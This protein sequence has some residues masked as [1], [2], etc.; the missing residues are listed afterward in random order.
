MEPRKIALL[1]AAIVVALVTALGARSLIKNSSAPVASAMPMPVQQT[2]PK[3]LVATR[4]LPVGTILDDASF[5]YQPWPKG[6]IEG[7]YYVEGDTAHSPN[8]LRGGVVRT[9]ISAG[10]PMTVGSVVQPGDRGFLAAALAPGMRAVTVP[11]SVA[12][13]VAGFV[14]P[15]DRIDIVLT[16]TVG[17]DGQGGSALRTSETIVRNLRVLATDQR[18]VSDDEKGNKEVKQFQT[19]T[20]EVTPRI[21]EKI[22][23]AQKIGDLS[24]SLRPI[25]DNASELERAIASGSVNMP[26]GTDPKMEKQMLVRIASQPSDSDTTYV[27]GADVSRFQRRSIPKA[28]A[29]AGASTLGGPSPSSSSPGNAPGSLLAPVVPRGPI[30]VIARGNATTQ[31]ETGGK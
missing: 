18:T 28:A 17:A 7:A 10:Q 24:L 26:A 3:V 13:G 9:A 29:P 20:L 6:L 22:A 30:V 4:A 2:G 12:T 15:G 14:F 11:V 21:G 8:S 31:V 27:T 1:V 19:V 16:Q 25:A 5:R 23:V